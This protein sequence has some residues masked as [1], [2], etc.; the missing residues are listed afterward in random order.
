MLLKHDTCLS[1]PSQARQQAF[2]SRACGMKAATQ[3]GEWKAGESKK[4][5]NET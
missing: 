5:P 2:A 3:A 4:Q 1:S